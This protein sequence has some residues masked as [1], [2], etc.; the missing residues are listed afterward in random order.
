N[1]CA[2]RELRR[3]DVRHERAEDREIN[4]VKKV[5]SCDQRDHSA[6]Q[7]RYLRLVER[8]A[9]IC[10]DGLSHGY[11]SLV[12]VF[13]GNP[14]TVVRMSQKLAIGQ[15]VY[16]GEDNCVGRD[17]GICEGGGWRFWGRAR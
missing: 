6:M 7:R 16:G 10:L 4:D 9:D 2:A 14:A 13:G 1:L 11:S 5:S 15:T 12:P 17:L 3:Q 8:V